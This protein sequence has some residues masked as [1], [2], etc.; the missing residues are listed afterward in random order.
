V[1]GS[2]RRIGFLASGL[3]LLWAPTEVAGQDTDAYDRSP[4]RELPHFTVRQIVTGSNDALRR[5]PGPWLRVA[6]EAQPE[7]LGRARYHTVAGLSGVAALS[8][9]ALESQ[10]SQHTSVTASIRYFAGT[11]T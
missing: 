11:D 6:M 5:I 7:S 3:L 1:S 2:G 8:G 9:K 10:R 4:S